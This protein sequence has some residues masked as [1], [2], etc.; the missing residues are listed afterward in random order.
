MRAKDKERANPAG[1]LGVAEGVHK[2]GAEERRKLT[3]I[4]NSFEAVIEFA[5]SRKPASLRAGLWR[6]F[7]ETEVLADD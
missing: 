7:L 1:R 3:G 6:C 2:Q 5:N 4:G